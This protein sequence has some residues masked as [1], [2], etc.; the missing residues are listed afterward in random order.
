MLRQET[1]EMELGSAWGTTSRV[2]RREE[3]K[4]TSKL[5]PATDILEN[6]HDR[7]PGTLHRSE[8]EHEGPREPVE[9]P[10]RNETSTIEE[11]H[12][13]ESKLRFERRLPK[14][15]LKKPDNEKD[16]KSGDP[17]LSPKTGRNVRPRETIEISD[18][19]E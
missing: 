13:R 17:E 7:L 15:S 8:S 1:L 18:E 6:R 16:W 12:D 19:N 3:A 4:Y 9:R 2:R 14:L 11:Y 5:V 10:G